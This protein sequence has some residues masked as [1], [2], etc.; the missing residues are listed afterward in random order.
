[1][2][3]PYTTMEITLDSDEVCSRCLLQLL[4]NS[5][6]FRIDSKLFCESC[7][8]INSQK[9]II[10]EPL[11]KS[12]AD[13]LV[14][15]RKP[16]RKSVSKWSNNDD[17]ML[18]TKWNDGVSIEDIAKEVKRTEN[19]V[20]SHI[21][22]LKLDVKL[23]RRLPPSIYQLRTIEKLGGSDVKSPRD[24][25]E[26][27]IMIDELIRKNGTKVS[28]LPS[29]ISILKFLGHEKEIPKNILEAEKLIKNYISIHLKKLGYVDIPEKTFDA[30][31][32]LR[33]IKREKNKEK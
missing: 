29:Q 31:N 33:K 16:L 28:P 27:S 30:L 21:R 2:I 32:L 7:D 15:S 20:R 11:L 25:S 18:E 14:K 24:T 8:T 5:N 4:K 6:A 23:G 19:S 12:R 17:V 26:A 10:N 9:N 1:M 3:P 22:K 13:L